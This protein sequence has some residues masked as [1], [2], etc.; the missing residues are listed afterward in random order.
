MDMATSFPLPHPVA[1]IREVPTQPSAQDPGQAP[2]H[3]LID[4]MSVPD[5]VPGTVNKKDENWHPGVLY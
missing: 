2:I 5:M 3:S 1:F 4:S